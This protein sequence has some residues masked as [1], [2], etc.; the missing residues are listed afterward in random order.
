MGSEKVDPNGE[1]D[2]D[3]AIDDAMCFARSL[4]AKAVA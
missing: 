4:D 1:L 3:D 2:V